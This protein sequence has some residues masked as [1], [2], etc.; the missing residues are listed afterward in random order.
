MENN[1]IIKFPEGL[2]K[3]GKECCL[4]KTEFE[5]LVLLISKMRIYRIRIDD[6]VKKNLSLITLPEVTR[7]GYKID[8]LAKFLQKFEVRWN[9]F[10]VLKQQEKDNF[11]MELFKEAWKI[12]KD[13]VETGGANLKQ[14]IVTLKFPFPS[15]PA[16]TVPAFLPDTNK[17]KK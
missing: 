10:Q 12:I 14:G 15:N 2:M 13:Y 9:F 17:I 4:D 6:I 3:K 7:L 8:I 1:P 11:D 5:R 16:P